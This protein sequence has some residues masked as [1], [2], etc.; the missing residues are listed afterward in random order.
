LRGEK[1][2]KRKEGG[3]ES[4]ILVGNQ[5]TSLLSLGDIRTGAVQLSSFKNRKKWEEG[6][7]RKRKKRERSAVTF[8]NQATLLVSLD[9]A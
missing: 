2:R 5:S 4:A 6:K 9:Y 3:I 8:A 7:K 1:T